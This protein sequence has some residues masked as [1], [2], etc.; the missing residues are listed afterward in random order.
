ML[1]TCQKCNSTDIMNEI[2]EGYKHVCKD[3]DIIAFIKSKDERI[4]E[5]ESVNYT[6][7]DKIKTFCFLYR[8]VLNN[9]ENEK[10]HVERKHIEQ[11]Y[12]ENKPLIYFVNLYCS[13]YSV[14]I[15]AAELFCKDPTRG[16]KVG[17][18]KEKFELL[19]NHIIQAQW[20]LSR[21]S[22]RDDNEYITTEELLLKI[23]SEI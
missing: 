15:E 7:N 4:K 18:F 19:R 2:D 3:E 1:L 11:L 20:D 6:Y 13:L 8:D 16:Y 9:L 21:N 10:I 14:W 12:S 23:K 17:D 5:L 22:K